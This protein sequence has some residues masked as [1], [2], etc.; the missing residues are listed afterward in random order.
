MA[1]PLPP[2]L[3]TGFGPGLPALEGFAAVVDAEKADPIRLILRLRLAGEEDA[4]TAARAFRDQRVELG[5][6]L[7]DPRA[8][9][10]AEKLQVSRSG[11]EVILQVSLT[12]SEADLLVGLLSGVSGLT[13][14]AP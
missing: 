10:I 11:R 8:A 4:G 2:E 13:G 7:P 1:G 3:R 5:A 12:S 14:S 6:A 9:A